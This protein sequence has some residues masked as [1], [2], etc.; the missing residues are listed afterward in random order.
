MLTDQAKADMARYH[1]LLLEWNEKIDLTNVDEPD[2]AERHY[3]D[4]LLPLSVD[5]L[6]PDGARVIDVGSGAGFPGMPIAIARRDLRV[7]L[8]D[9][10]RKRCDFLNAV[11]EALPLENVTVVHMRAED[12]GHAPGLREAY[13]L[14]LARAVAPLCVLAEYLLPLVRVGGR[15]VCWKGPAVLTELDA[16][17]TACTLL[18]GALGVRTR[19]DLPGREHYIQVLEK[20][21]KTVP[22]YPRKSGTPARKPLGTPSK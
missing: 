4:S 1:A 5:G 3:L 11:R 17:K 22:Q 18:G 14:A 9:A 20:R 15:A 10:Q 8:M 2:M 12:A 13:D 7:T 6:F 21:E 16:A 19:L